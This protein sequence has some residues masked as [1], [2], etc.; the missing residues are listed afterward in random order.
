MPQNCILIV[1]ADHPLT[2][3]AAALCR[4][5]FNHVIVADEDDPAIEDGNLASQPCDLLISFLN[6]H[7]LPPQLLIHTNVNFHPGPP[8]YP[9][10]GGASY[11]L[12]EG[13]K[14]YGATAHVMAERVDTGA[15][16]LASEFPIDADESCETLFAKAEQS[17]LDLL[18]SALATFSETGRLPPPNGMR[19]SRRPS[20][21]KQFDQWLILDPADRTTFDRKIVAAQ[22]SR[23]SGPYVFVNGLK[24]G[25]VNDEHNGATIKT[26]RATQRSCKAK[27]SGQ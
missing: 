7:I 4:S 24:F 19:W 15:I 8:Q 2:P 10:R 17:T 18:V 13:A 25:L 16:I 26:M 1:D 22:H 14:T 11:A 20:T 12:F 3:D 9:G 5:H 6:A 23:F 21:R 27:I